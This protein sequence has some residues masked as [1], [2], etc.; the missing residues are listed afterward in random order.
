[1]TDAGRRTAISP[2]E[3]EYREMAIAAIILRGRDIMGRMPLPDVFTV[4]EVVNHFAEHGEPDANELGTA[5]LRLGRNDGPALLYDLL[6]EGLLTADALVPH[7]GNV[8]NAA[9][10]PD[11]HLSHD[12]WRELFQFAGYTRNGRAEAPPAK[13]LTLYRGSVPERRADW[14]WTDR[15]DIATGYAQGTKAR[16]PVG[17]VWQATVEPWRLLARNEGPENRDESEYVV[18]TEGLEIHALE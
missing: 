18:D 10:Y 5:L 17:Q 4:T 12:V 2:A 1:M 6:M 15:L 11:R 14:S 9:E 16:R 13:P 7:I 8:W 3:R